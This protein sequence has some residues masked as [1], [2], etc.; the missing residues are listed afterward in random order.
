MLWMNKNHVNSKSFQVRTIGNEVDMKNSTF[1]E[2]KYV[3]MENKYFLKIKTLELL[4]GRDS[5]IPIQPQLRIQDSFCSYKVETK[6]KA[7]QKIIG[8]GVVKK[9]QQSQ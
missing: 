4:K 3:F 6:A 1:A 2:L 7:V 8:L 5:K 9:T